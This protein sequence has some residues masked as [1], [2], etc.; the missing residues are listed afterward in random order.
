M[1]YSMPMMGGDVFCGSCYGGHSHCS[2]PTN[3]YDNQ[4]GQLVRKWADSHLRKKQPY[5]G[6]A[7]LMRYQGGGGHLIGG[8]TFGP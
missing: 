6:D 7:W 4:R 5:Q 2:A 3:G 1:P 8:A